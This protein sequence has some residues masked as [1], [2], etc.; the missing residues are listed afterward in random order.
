M[1]DYLIDNI[2]LKGV[3]NVLNETNKAMTNKAT[4]YPEIEIDCERSTNDNILFSAEYTI[5][6][7]ETIVFFLNDEFDDIG[8]VKIEM[9]E[10][11]RE[12]ADHA[13]IGSKMV[14]DAYFED[15]VE[16]RV[17]F[18]EWAKESGEAM[19]KL[20][21]FV[22]E[23]INTNSNTILADLKAIKQGKLIESVQRKFQYMFD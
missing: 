11:F 2:D 16:T 15:E 7:D 14:G 22:N 10:S 5:D 23:F 21:E 6:T 19:N 8:S 13:L 12:W 3:R 17:D 20:Q 1:S 18:S 9:P 4:H